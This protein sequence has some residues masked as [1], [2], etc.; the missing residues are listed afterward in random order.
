[1]HKIIR[2]IGRNVAQ[3]TVVLVPIHIINK[4]GTSF[5]DEEIHRQEVD[6]PV[7]KGSNLNADSKLLY[8]LDS[9]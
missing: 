9:K 5:L 7:P 3:N 6:H 2:E 8:T 4:V 1:M